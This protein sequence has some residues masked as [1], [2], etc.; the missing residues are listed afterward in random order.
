MATASDFVFVVGDDEVEISKGTTDR[1]VANP[2]SPPGPVILRTKS[3]A[4]MVDHPTPGDGVLTY[5]VRA[6]SN[7]EYLEPEV[8][9]N[10]RRVGRIQRTLGAHPANLYT[11][12]IRVDSEALRHGSNTLKISLALREGEPFDSR[13]PINADSFW[14]RAM[15][16]HYRKQV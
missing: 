14:V 16:C 10:D 8:T 1:V 11:Q 5:M 6:L 4:F 2:G 9:I 15:V 13:G 3:F 12:V 7:A